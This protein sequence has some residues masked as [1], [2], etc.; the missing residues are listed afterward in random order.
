MA[1]EIND[2]QI[3][4]AKFRG[5]FHWH[6]HEH[7]DEF[8]FVHRGQLLMR[9]RDREVRLGPGEFVIVPR[10]VEHLPVAE[11][12]D[13]EIVLLERKTTLNTGNVENKRTVRHLGRVR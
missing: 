13:C 1:G 4:L 2:V 6:H 5:A 8:F 12:E 7:E 11:T 10:M 9:F 3:K